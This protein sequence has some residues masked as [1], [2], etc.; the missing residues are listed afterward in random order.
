MRRPT[1]AREALGPSPRVQAGGANAAR[2]EAVPFVA[3][4][5]DPAVQRA[6]DGG[7]FRFAGLLLFFNLV[8]WKHA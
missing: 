5:A 1:A 6:A 8:L 2:V 3:A 7:R 4:G